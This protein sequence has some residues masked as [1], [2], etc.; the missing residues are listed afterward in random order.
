MERLNSLPF[1]FREGACNTFEDSSGKSAL[2][3]SDFMDSSNDIGSLD[4]RYAKTRS[5]LSGSK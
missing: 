5:I 4:T 2:K 3:T 1:N